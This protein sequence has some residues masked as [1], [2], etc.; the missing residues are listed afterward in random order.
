MTAIYGVPQPN[1]PV[2]FVACFFGPTGQLPAFVD[3][4]ITV[5]ET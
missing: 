4:E 1:Y 3:I 5:I 2:A